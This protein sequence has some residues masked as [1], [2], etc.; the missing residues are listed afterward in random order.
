MTIFIIMLIA[1]NLI[2]GLERVGLAGAFPG[3]EIQIELKVAA[4]MEG[5]S[6]SEAGNYGKLSAS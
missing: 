1:H 2:L 4:V 5:I 3:G 6:N